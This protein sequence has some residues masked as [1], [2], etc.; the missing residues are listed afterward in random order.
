MDEIAGE[1]HVSKKT[2]YKYFPSKEN[3]LE[4][5]CRMTSKYLETHIKN[6]VAS[7]NDVVTKFV[8]LLILHRNFIMNISEKWL[9]DLRI[10]APQIKHKIDDTRN[11]RIEYISS[12]LIEQGKRDKLI[13]DYPTQIIIAIL[14]SSFTEIFKPEFIIQNK[15]SLQDAFIHTYDIIM[16]GI[17]TDKGKERYKKI[18]PLLS[19]KLIYNF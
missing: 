14:T 1:L 4:E 2:I 9:T 19:K 5:I 8:E 6:I 7:K 15:F 16:N 13:E 11:E 18:K 12:K 17:L 3:L 10:H